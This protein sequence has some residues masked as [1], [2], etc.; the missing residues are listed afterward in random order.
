MEKRVLGFWG[1]G[2]VAGGWAEITGWDSSLLSSKDIASVVLF[3]Y[4]LG[5]DRW[6]ALYRYV[7]PSSEILPQV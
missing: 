2:S 1:V 4:F 6:H 7:F 5:L 3:L